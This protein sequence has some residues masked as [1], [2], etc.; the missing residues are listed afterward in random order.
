MKGIICWRLALDERE[1]LQGGILVA[2]R[3]GDIVV[4]L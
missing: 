2:E 3:P 1:R 4:T